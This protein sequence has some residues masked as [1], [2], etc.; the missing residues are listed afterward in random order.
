MSGPITTEHLNA[1]SKEYDMIEGFLDRR[2][3]DGIRETEH[4]WILG[5]I[6]INKT[7]PYFRWGWG[8]ALSKTSCFRKQPFQFRGKDC[9]AV[10][11]RQFDEKEHDKPAEEY[12]AGWAWPEQEGDLD[13]W[14]AFMNAEIADRLRNAESDR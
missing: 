5:S 10:I 12:I 6:A 11:F 3:I 8:F 7:C 4:E 9:L 2:R 14:I 13:T 1:H